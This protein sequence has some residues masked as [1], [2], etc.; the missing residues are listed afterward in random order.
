MTY[1]DLTGNTNLTNA[2]LNWLTEGCHAMKTLKLYGLDR[3]D[4][5]GMRCLSE[6]MGELLD[7][8]LTGVNQITDVGVRHLALGC[9]KI[10]RLILSG[11][12]LLTNGMDRDFGLEG[13]QALA[14]E[15]TTL[16]SLN[17]A[18]CFQVGAQSLGAVEN[19][20][21]LTELR[22]GCQNIDAKAWDC[23][24]ALSKFKNY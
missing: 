2:G 14:K 7:L 11:V 12:Y 23:C 1:L 5:A 3:L 21:G 20:T 10:E 4:D 15:I 6:G 18:N 17:L 24:K 19:D 8:D 22:Y 9:K 13:L 16:K